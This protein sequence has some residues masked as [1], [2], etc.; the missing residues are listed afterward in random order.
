MLQASGHSLGHQID[1]SAHYELLSRPL[2]FIWKVPFSLGNSDNQMDSKAVGQKLIQC[3]A[4]KACKSQLGPA[5]PA[6]Q[7]EQRTRQSLREQ[8]REAAVRI[9]PPAPRWHVP[10]CSLLGSMV[11]LQVPPESCQSCRVISGLRIV[12]NAMLS[13][14][15]LPLA[16]QPLI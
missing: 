7:A 8:K 9:H 6:T 10:V 16:V 13:H 11:L 15:R 5:R 2:T 3:P 1:E 14:F 4:Q 12:K